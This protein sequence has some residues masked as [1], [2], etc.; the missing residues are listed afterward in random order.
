MVEFHFHSRMS[1]YAD[2]FLDVYFFLHEKNIFWHFS[3]EKE[4]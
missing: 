1:T 3:E 4:D 2:I